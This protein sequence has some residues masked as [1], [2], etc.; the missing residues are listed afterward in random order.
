ME[1]KKVIQSECILFGA[2]V[3]CPLKKR[4][5]DCVLKP[6]IGQSLKETFMGINGMNARR[7]IY[8]AAECNLCVQNHDI[9]FL[10]QREKQKAV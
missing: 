4:K 8:L 3:E 9:I 1:Q 10:K 2:C 7:K 5:S 6:L